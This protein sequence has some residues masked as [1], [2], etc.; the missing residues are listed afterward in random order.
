MSAIGPRWITTL[1]SSMIVAAA[2]LVA[3]SSDS[4]GS[5]NVGGT[6][7]S[8]ASDAGGAGGTAGTA[9]KTSVGECTGSKPIADRPGFQRCEEA[10]E[11]RPTAEQCNVPAP[12]K[13]GQS[14]KGCK[15]NAEC[16][17]EPNG[18]CA[19]TLPPGS[20]CTCIYGCTQDSDCAAG[21]LC[22]CGAERSFCATA[23]CRTDAD[24]GAGK[25]CVETLFDDC[26][27]GYACQTD[28]DECS[29]GTCGDPEPP[30]TDRPACVMTGGK[31]SCKKVN[32]C[33][34]DPTSCA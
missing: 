18:Y 20:T 22:K 15:S 1:S 10:I 5:G 33:C 17:A 23:K 29:R 11:H 25:L 8:A 26:T 30:S 28:A 24:C 19:G 12:S 34:I 21:Q 3:C 27:R 31:R 2:M 9:G 16:T 32:V 6:G 4:G 14:P 7:G 13:C